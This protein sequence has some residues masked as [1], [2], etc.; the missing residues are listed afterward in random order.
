MLWIVRQVWLYRS[1]IVLAVQLLKALRKTARETAQEYIR[2]KVAAKLRKQVI[3]VCTQ[4]GLLLGAFWLTQAYRGLETRL[5]AS[6][7]LWGITLFNL[8]QFCFSTIPEAIALRKTLK[9]KVGYA[10][11]YVLEVSLVT[12]LMQ[13]NIVFLAVC[14]VLGISSRTYIGRAFEY[15]EPWIKWLERLS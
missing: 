9:G 3:A 12:E 6:V 13:L 4:I 14:L 10:L 11:K 15:F 1:E 8:I 5:L 2:R 7:V